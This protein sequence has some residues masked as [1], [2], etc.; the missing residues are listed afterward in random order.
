MTSTHHIKRILLPIDDTLGT[1]AAIDYAILL[2]TALGA[3]LTLVHVDEAPHSMVGIVPGA[4]VEGDLAAERSTSTRRLHELVAEISAGGFA[5][6]TCLHVE[7]P[8]IAS[9]IVTAATAY[10]LVVMATHARTG[11]SR[12]VLGSIAEQV[13]RHASCPV[14]TVHV[15]A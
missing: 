13:L 9:A 6:V 5:D 12:L 3:S 10:D 1:E 4:T 8:A 14:L 7:A 15:P 11:V 2:A